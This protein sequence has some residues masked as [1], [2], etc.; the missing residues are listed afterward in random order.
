MEIN[1]FA[2]I[3]KKTVPTK[4]YRIIFKTSLIIRDIQLHI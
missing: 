4:F 1:T 3:T 2:K